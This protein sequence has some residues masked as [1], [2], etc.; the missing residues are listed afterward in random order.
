MWLRFLFEHR[1]RSQCAVEQASLSVVQAPHEPIISMLHAVGAKC[2]MRALG[3]EL[4][5]AARWAARQARARTAVLHTY[6]LEMA[7][8]SRGKQRKFEPLIVDEMNQVPSGS[9]P[10]CFA[11]A[12]ACSTA[13]VSDARTVSNRPDIRLNANRATDASLPSIGSTA[14]SRQPPTAHQRPSKQVIQSKAQASRRMHRF[15]VQGNH[16]VFSDSFPTC[17]RKAQA[18]A[19]HALGRLLSYRWIAMVQC[20]CTSVAG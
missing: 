19:Q 14:P 4:D 17:E 8:R 12:S 11:G 7:H 20:C 16:H 5:A 15:S 13:A 2:H 6:L 18:Q 3:A 10:S 1:M 9:V